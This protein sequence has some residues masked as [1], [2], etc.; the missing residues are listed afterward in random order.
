MSYA[1]FSSDDWRSDVYVYHSSNG[2]VVNVA[3]TRPDLS[4]VELPPPIDDPYDTEAWVARENAVAKLVAE[5]PKTRVGHPKAGSNN[6]FLLASEAHAFLRT[7]ADE[8]LHVPV[9]AFEFLARD[10]EMEEVYS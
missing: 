4:G 8:G 3:L 9:E 1:R 2:Y 7:L 6:V 5:S 10:A